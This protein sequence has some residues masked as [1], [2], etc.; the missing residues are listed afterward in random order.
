MVCNYRE[1]SYSVAGWW[2]LILEGW[3]EP[4]GSDATVAFRFWGRCGKSLFQNPALMSNSL[5]A[6]AGPQRIGERQIL[7]TS[8]Q[9][10]QIWMLYLLPSLLWNWSH[11]QPCRSPV[12]MLQFVETSSAYELNSAC[13]SRGAQGRTL[14]WP[15]H[16]WP[17]AIAEKVRRHITT[18]KTK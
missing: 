9:I 2:E 7:F 4:S 18:I 8:G 11:R 16:F 3:A 17:P 14:W 10:S 6:P 13:F 15:H 5:S 1:D 12:W